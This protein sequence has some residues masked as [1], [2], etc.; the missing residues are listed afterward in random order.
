V[1]QAQHRFR[2]ADAPGAGVTCNGEGLFV[3]ETPL[4]QKTEDGDG[5]VRWQARAAADLDRDLSRTYGLPVA[6]ADRANGLAAIAEAL[7]R[8]DLARA[9]ITALY[10]KL[11]DPLPTTRQ[12]HPDRPGVETL[13]RALAASNLLKLEWDESKHPRWPAGSPDGVG[14]EFAPTGGAASGGGGD[15]TLTST[16]G[17]SIPMEIPWEEPRI[18]QFPSEIVPP[19]ITGPIPRNPYRDRP[20]CVREWEEAEKYCDEL[21]RKGRLGTHPPFGQHGR[22][23]DECIRGQVSEDCGG[24]PVV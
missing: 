1:I 12:G 10:L 18:A 14:G 13:F 22:T 23:Y 24:N 9:Q 4:L 2:L 20:R 11:P 15:Q 6:F 16:Q 21:D 3:G 5:V 17:A 7:D 19:P 8:S